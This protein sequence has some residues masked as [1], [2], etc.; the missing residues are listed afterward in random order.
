MLLEA[1]GS[2]RIDVVFDVYREVSIKNVEG[3][4]RCLTSGKE[5][6]AKTWLKDTLSNNGGKFSI[7]RTTK[8]N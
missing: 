4:N 3:Y 2:L 1:S 6:S 5:Y 8:H 7:V